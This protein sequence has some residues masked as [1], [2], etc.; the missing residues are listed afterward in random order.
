MRLYLYYLS[1]QSPELQLFVFFCATPVLVKHMAVCIISS[2]ILILAG[3]NWN[4]NFVQKIL[5]YLGIS[6]LSGEI[7]NL[8]KSQCCSQHIYRG[9][10]K[11]ISEDETELNDVMNDVALGRCRPNTS[12]RISSQKD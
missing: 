7:V 6:V 12:K 10:T 8:T 1:T 3:Q 11:T 4:S 2:Q 5:V 9:K